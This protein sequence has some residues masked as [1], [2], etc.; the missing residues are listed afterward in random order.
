M[1]TFEAA[2]VKFVVLLVLFAWC[3][4]WC[5]YELTRP[6]DA[7]QRTSNVLHLAMAVVMVLMVTPPTWKALTDAVPVFLLVG[8]FALAVAWFVGLAAASFRTADRRAGWHFAG[9]A[10]MFGAMAWHLWAMGAMEAGMSSAM[11][12]MDHGTGMG[13]G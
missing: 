3:T 9:H 5:A 4:A 10:A 1:F 13:T 12:G 8:V 7:R 11:D 2:P 6:Q